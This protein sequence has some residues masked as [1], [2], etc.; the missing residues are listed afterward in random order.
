MARPEL[1]KINKLNEQQLAQNLVII[2]DDCIDSSDAVVFPSEDEIMEK[3]LPLLP[4]NEE[5]PESDVTPS[6]DQPIAVVWE[7]D[8]GS[9]EWYIGFFLDYNKDKTMSINHLKRKD[10]GEHISWV[11]PNDYD[12]QSV[13]EQQILPVKVQGIWDFTSTCSSKTVFKLE[14]PSVIIEIFDKVKN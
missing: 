11:Q 4:N 5:L 1:Y 9:W 8:N 10:I 12:I 2:F 3:L 6:Q 14:N 7:E 13:H